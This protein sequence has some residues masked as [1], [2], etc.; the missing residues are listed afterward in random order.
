VQS[1]I[2]EYLSELIDSSRRV[3]GDVGPA[4]GNGDGH[5]PGAKLS[6]FARARVPPQI[7]RKFNDP[8]LRFGAQEHEAVSG[9]MVD[10]DWIDRAKG[11]E[12]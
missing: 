4:F 5:P 10:A 6:R 8:Y 12:R 2:I 9:V 7:L 11:E 3:Q 1:I